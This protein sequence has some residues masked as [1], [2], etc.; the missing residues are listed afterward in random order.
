[1]AAASTRNCA[2]YMGRLTRTLNTSTRSSTRLA[3]QCVPSSTRFVATR[4]FVTTVSLAASVDITAIDVPSL[5]LHVGGDATITDMEDDEGNGR[6][7]HRR[8]ALF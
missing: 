5:L 7:K 1:M 6:A 8:W 2:R 3:F 4:S